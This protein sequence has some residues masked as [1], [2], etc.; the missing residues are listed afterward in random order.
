MLLGR[1]G[2]LQEPWGSL[3][4]SHSC[5]SMSPIRRLD[6]TTSINEQLLSMPDPRLRAGCCRQSY[7]AETLLQVTRG[8]PGTAADSHRR[9]MGVERALGVTGTGGRQAVMGK[10]R[11][12]GNLSP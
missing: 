5:P 8:L 4:E 9:A 6:V 1:P 11:Q 7:G 3:V 12:G 2:E 10:A